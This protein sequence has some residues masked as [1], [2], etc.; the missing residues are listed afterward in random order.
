MRS[1]I[2]WGY[3]WLVALGV[4]L[5]SATAVSLG[6]DV[7]IDPDPFQTAI[8]N[9]IS[10]TLIPCLPGV[11]TLLLAAYNDNPYPGGPGLGYSRSTDGGTIWSAGQL[12]Y[13]TNRITGLSMTQAFD[14][15]STHDRLGNV[16]LGQIAWDSQGYSAMFVHRSADL[17]LTWT[18]VEVA[19]D[20]PAVP[21]PPDPNFRLNDRCQLAS[22]PRPGSLA[23]DNIYVAW[24]K[25]RGN[26]P[27]NP[28]GDIYVSA[29]SDSG[30]TY[31]SALRINDAGHD[32]GN[33]PTLAVASDGTLYVA[34]MD[35][36]VLT[37]G[38]GTIYLDQS[39]NGGL[40]WGTD[41]GVATISL[42]PLHV[43]K[44]DGSP[45]ARAKGA[46]VLAVSP[47][48]PQE[49]YL[50]YAADPDG[51]GADEADIFL[52][53]STNGG[54]SWTAPLR[55]NDDTT[56]TDQILPWI[57]VKSDGTIELAW[58]DRRND[59]VPPPLGDRLW[60]VFWTSSS[61][62]GSSFLP[63]TR[64]SDTS[65]LTP[66]VGSEYWMGEYLGLAVDSAYTYFAFTSSVSDTL[67]DLYFDKGT[68]P[69]GAEI[70]EPAT[71]SL[72]ALG[73]L[74]LWRRRRLR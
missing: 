36:N 42:P 46:P 6:P 33:M 12:P 20:T 63:S 66:F 10:L 4:C 22:G 70:P 60:D 53:K 49:L 71:L 5:R 73:G 64:V 8:Q 7:N 35:Y 25:D 72:L 56:I 34:W 43:T 37:G 39:A 14:P 19:L 15:A 45:D 58:Y 3:W 55:V 59:P 26:D 21:P 74:A 11:P 54:T 50:V 61:D 32:L 29:S 51:L 47:A 2:A 27:S 48:N 31:T 40:A 1:G 18:P 16:Y 28:F 13:P 69:A 67:G 23:N 52:I 57:A 62:A 44:G 68:T 24:I 65:F 38:T 17:G 9:E 41:Q 30:V